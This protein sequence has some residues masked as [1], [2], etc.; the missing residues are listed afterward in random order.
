M[1]ARNPLIELLDYG[2]SFWLD[3]IRRGFIETGELKAMID[4]DGLR[5]ITSNPSIFEKAIAGSTDYRAQLD[6]LRCEKGLDPQRMFERLAVKDIQAAA[7]LLR[8]VYDSSGKGDG[9]VSL[10]VSPGLANDTEGTIREARELWKAVDRP[11]LMVKVPGTTAGAPAFETL[12]AEGINI[13]VTLLFAVEAYE[14]IAEAYI[15][16]LEKRAKAGQP[17]DFIASVASFFVSRIDTAVDA[18]LKAKAEAAQGDERAHIESLYGKTAIANAKRAYQRFQA[19]FSGPRWDALARKG[20]KPQR[21]LWASTSTKNPSYR[22]VIYIEELIGP[23]TVNTMPPATAEAFRDHGRLRNSLQ[24]DPAAAEAVLN[25]IAR[26]GIDLKAVTAKLTIDGVKQFTDAYDKMLDAIRESVKPLPK[27]VTHLPAPL[28]QKVDQV[29]AEWEKS[30]KT[31]R[32]WDGDTSVWTNAD[33]NKWLGWLHIA[34][35]QSSH[36]EHLERFRDEVKKEGFQHA[37]VLGMGGSSLAPEVLS[38]TFGRQN[39]FPQLEILDSTD[40]AQIRA[41]ESRLDLKKTLFIVSSKSGSTLEPNLYYEYF[42][43][44]VDAQVGRDKAGHQFVAVTDPG[45]SMEKR[46]KE[47]GFRHVFYGVPSIGGRYSALS[48]FGMVPAAAMGLDV[49]RLLDRAETM[50]HSCASCVPVRENP[51]FALGSILG[52]LGRDGR[53]KVTIVASPAIADFGAWLEQLLAESTG[54]I[55]RGLIPVDQEPL[56][57]PGVYGNDR[58]F[59]YIRFTPKPDAHQDEALKALAAAGQP[60]VQID[61]ADPYDVGMEFFRWEFATAVAGSI[62]GINPFDQPDVEASKVASRELTSEYEE[63]GK[64]PEQPPLASG[65]GISIFAADRSLASAKG[66]TVADVLSALFERIKPGDYVAF[67]AY[68]PRNDA[69]TEAITDMRIAVRDERHVATCGGFGPRFLH[70]TGQAYKGGPNSGVFVQITC[71]NADDL[72]VPGH[73]YTFGVVKTAQALGDL[74]VLNERGRRA[75]RVHLPGNVKQGL[76][77]LEDLVRQA[78]TAGQTARA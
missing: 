66:A 43:S 67:L 59:A 12:I 20:A 54:K 69:N 68:I 33:E 17:I 42:R 47:D 52:A 55:G 15:R 77:T 71:E 21:V 6:D 19:A 45:S 62:L 8:P 60:V 32:I 41:L 58:L 50:A 76:S 9:F 3:F 28:Q 13:N 35:E 48:D 18:Q 65:D 70:S 26:L 56:G 46:A 78:L 1:P 29:A 37:V 7:D 44:R 30:G 23:H 38:R 64:L 10:E 51:G 36:I 61:V 74:Q 49:A 63:T 34:D 24:E 75:V 2:Q 14:N 39:G 11:N 27:Q 5:G 22:D 73:K 4:N 25:E 57:N 53:D 40:P 31:K 16:A 72:D